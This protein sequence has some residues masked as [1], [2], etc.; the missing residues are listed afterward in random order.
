MKVSAWSVIKNESQ[1]IGYG[2]LSLLQWVDEIVYFDGNSTDG[3]L[4]ILDHI[5]TKYDPQNKIRVFMDKDFKD[6]KEDYVK[7]FN[8]C[9]KAC[10]GD[11]LFYCHP[12]MI[13]TDPGILAHRDRMHEKAY[14]VNMR[15]FAG[16]DLD[17]EITK[18]RSDKWKLIM[19]N[20]FGIHYAGYYGSQEEDMYFR[21]ITGDSH[22][23]HTDMNKYPYGVADSGIRLNHYCECKPM[24]RRA[25]KMET[26]VRTNIKGVD[27]VFVKDVVFNHPR[28][29]L[30]NKESK[31]GNFEFKP[32]NESLPYIFQK[33]KDEI[34]GLLK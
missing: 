8:D 32:R 34:E 23:L 21:A 18:G 9:M 7:T 27:D 11:F 26:V 29:H 2:A 14:Y 17:M 5:K 15:S 6:F 19:F 28:V 31:W 20:G 10:T 22:V 1:F 16:E 4:K 25:K 24:N 12:D 3:T 30:Q 13:L 33:F